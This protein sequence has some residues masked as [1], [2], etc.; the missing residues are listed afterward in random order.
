MISLK[1]EKKNLQWGVTS[2]MP[3]YQYICEHCEEECEV[4]H[5]IL[6]TL[7]N[8]TCSNCKKGEL[9][10]LLSNFN[11]GSFDNKQLKKP[12][13]TVKD[14]IKTSA[15]ELNDEKERLRRDRND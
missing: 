1:I 2:Y 5:S 14:F 4:F 6:E 7:P 12:G 13:D 3:F 10:R 11:I 15:K 9:V 8:T